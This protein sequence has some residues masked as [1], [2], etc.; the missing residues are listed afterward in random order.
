M[1]RQEVLAYVAFAIVCVVWGT[2]YLAIRIAIETIPPILLTG[3]RFTIAG[4]VMLALA[5]LR[6][7]R[8]SF[9]RR[10]LSIL[11]VVGFL[12]VG[13]GNLSVVW[14]EQ[15]VPSGMA[16]LFVATA[17]IWLLII[18]RF[19]SAGERV[20][21]RALFGMILGFLGVAMLVT[22][23]STPGR[24]STGFVLGGLAIQLGSI[25][26]QLGTV[27]G[28]Q[29]LKNVPAFTSAG[30]QMLFGGAILLVVGAAAGEI[31]RFVVTPKTLGALV[32]LIVFGSI[33]AYGAYVYALAHMPTTKLALYAYVN[34]VVAVILGW[35]ILDERLT[36]LSFGA[37]A[38]I[39]IGVALVQSAKAVEREPLPVEVGAQRTA[40]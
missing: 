27:V 24:F 17:P 4:V 21:A 9:D 11:T 22:P 28:K 14:A 23:G 12:M 25:C 33:A 26:W 16:A 37:M 19:R 29:E 15:W 38:V 8:L 10:T 5:R 31:P 32:Y 35:L 3:V 40:A 34:P 36:A 7:E 39:L 30:M 1:K 6:R 13:V 18:E 20:T 2:T